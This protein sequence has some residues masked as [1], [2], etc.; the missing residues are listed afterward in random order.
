MPSWQSRIAN[1]VIRLWVRPALGDMRDIA[2]M[3]RV[4]ARP[5]PAPTG[6]VYRQAVVGGVVGEWVTAVDDDAAEAAGGQAEPTTPTM[7]L[8]LHG[9][10]FV[11]CSPT[12]HRALTAALA[13]QG[14]RVFAPDYRLAPEHP[15]PAAIADA[16]AVWRALVVEA[17]SGSRR[18]VAGDSAGGNLALAMMLALRDAAQPLPHAAALFSPA[19][20]LTGGSAS[21]KSNDGR[22]PMFRSAA[23]RHL[24][25]A[26][27]AGADPLMPL[28]SPLHADLAGLPPLLIHV[29]A[30]EVLRDDSLR[31]AARAR[32]AGVPVELRVWPGMPHV[33]QMLRWL[34]EARESV[35]AAARHLR[36]AV[37][38]TGVAQEAFLR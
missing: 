36:E 21:L 7:L 13:L 10:G 37:P 33:W 22:D 35:R 4:F 15:F 3:R 18:V 1:A 38:T 9:G 17:G 31:L 25:E 29:G 8:Y 28:A 5:L 24:A 16:V 6:V 34:P 2:R 14:L 30:D 19:T 27:L 11:A 12:T 20:D 26:Y 32:A 23:L